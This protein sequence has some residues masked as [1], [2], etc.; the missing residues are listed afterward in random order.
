[1]TAEMSLNNTLSP[2]SKN[3]SP[4]TQEEMM[5]EQAEITEKMNEFVLE[6]WDLFYQRRGKVDSNINALSIQA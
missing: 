1:M 6:L 4:W 5:T 2:A 3:L